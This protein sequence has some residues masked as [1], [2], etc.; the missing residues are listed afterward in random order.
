ME[1]ASIYGQLGRQEEA[2]AAVANFV[3]LYPGIT[4][5]KAREEL[6][7]WFYSGDSVDHFIEGLPRVGL[8]E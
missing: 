3:E 8:P 1:L 7:K 4:G 6:R 2:R 5:K